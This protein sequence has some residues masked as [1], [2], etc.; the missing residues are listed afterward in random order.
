[1]SPELANAVSGGCSR[2]GS[3]QP[4]LSQLCPATCLSS[5]AAILGL[6]MYRTVANLNSCNHRP[7]KLTHG[8]SQEKRVS[9]G[10]SMLC[11]MVHCAPGKISWQFSEHSLF[12]AL[13]S[14]VYVVGAVLRGASVAALILA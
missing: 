11:I 2:L 5:S 10:S 12:F 9:A 3:L 8:S 1:M 13:L 14:T 4:I 7:W 6:V